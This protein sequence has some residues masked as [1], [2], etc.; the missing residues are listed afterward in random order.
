[1]LGNYYAPGEGLKNGLY[2]TIVKVL[3]SA[4]VRPCLTWCYNSTTETRATCWWLDVDKHF[5]AIPLVRLSSNHVEEL[6]CSRERDEKWS[7]YVPSS[8]VEERKGLSSSH[9]VLQRYTTS[10]LVCWTDCHRRPTADGL[11]E[12]LSVTICGDASATE[13]MDFLLDDEARLSWW[14]GFQIHQATINLYHKQ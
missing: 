11:T 13:A 2:I 12:Y 10:E 5:L 7:L 8:N 3:R 14:V 9:L 1:M 4:R 6:L